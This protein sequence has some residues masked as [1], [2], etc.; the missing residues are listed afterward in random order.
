[1]LIG[2]TAGLASYAKRV[3]FR[4]AFVSSGSTASNDGNT[5]ER[6]GSP[7]ANW[8]MFSPPIILVVM[9]MLYSFVLNNM[10][11]NL[12]TRVIGG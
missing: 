4:G 8:I 2:D 7:W 12:I 5:P 1:M 11:D 10:S 3:V 9:M 6:P